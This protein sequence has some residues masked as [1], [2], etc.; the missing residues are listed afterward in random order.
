MERTVLTVMEAA[1]E[2]RISRSMMYQL[3]RENKVPHVDIGKRKVIPAAAFYAWL[4]S[5]VT[6]G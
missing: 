1:A 3:I 4:N 5:S 6:G 2:M